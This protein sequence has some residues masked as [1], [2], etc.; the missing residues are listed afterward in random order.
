MSIGGEKTFLDLGAVPHIPQ[1]KECSNLDVSSRDDD[2]LSDVFVECLIRTAAMTMYHPVGT[3][4]RGTVLTQDFRYSE[5]LIKVCKQNVEF[6]TC[7]YLD[8]S[9]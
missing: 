3:A 2:D 4:A 6:A 7:T 5:K 1:F 8:S 9:K